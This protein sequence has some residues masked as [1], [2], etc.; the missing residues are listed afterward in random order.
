M[1]EQLPTAVREQVEYRQ[2]ADHEVIAVVGGFSNMADAT[3][4]SES[5]KSATG[6]DVSAKRRE[7]RTDQMDDPLSLIPPRFDLD[8]PQALEFEF[9]STADVPRYEEI[10]ALVSGGS[11]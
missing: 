1:T 3:L 9:Q 2:G 8:V 11:R 5:V 6:H 7:A 4:V 10:N